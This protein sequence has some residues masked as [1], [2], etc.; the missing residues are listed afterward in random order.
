MVR[1]GPSA[2]WLCPVELTPAL[3]ARARALAVTVFEA[4]GCR[5]MARVDLRIDERGE[6]FFLEINPLPSFD[7]EG[8]FG[9]I[10]ECLGTTYARLVGEI[11][12]A[13]LHRLG[14]SAPGP[15]GH[16]ATQPLQ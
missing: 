14:H 7:P 16:R 12:D 13:A 4:L 6:L 10:A 11:L 5:D 1:G 15:L 2:S 8:S 3:D 9:L